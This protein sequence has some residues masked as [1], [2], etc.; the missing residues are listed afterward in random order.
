MAPMVVPAAADTSA[1]YLG[2]ESA[3]RTFCCTYA[4]MVMGNGIYFDAM[5]GAWVP[6]KHGHV[7]FTAVRGIC[8]RIIT[9]APQAKCPR[10]QMSI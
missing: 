6:R 10:H 7:S 4:G 9:V 2:T 8:E 1:A 3:G 5:M